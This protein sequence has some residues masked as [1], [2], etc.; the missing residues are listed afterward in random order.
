MRRAIVI[1]VTKWTIGLWFEN[2]TPNNWRL[3]LRIWCRHKLVVHVYTGYGI[4]LSDVFWSVGV[5]PLHENVFFGLRTKR[6]EI[7]DRREKWWCRVDGC[8]HPGCGRRKNIRS[9]EAEDPNGRRRPSLLLLTW[10]SVLFY[11]WN[12]YGY[13]FHFKPGVAG[14]LPWNI[15][16]VLLKI[17]NEFGK[18][19]KKIVWK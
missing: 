3:G 9:E 5:V 4:E 1:N 14:L 12:G 8:Y 10:V 13:G 15:L 19:G 11:P 17:F 2:F 7:K 18:Y 16:F 6:A